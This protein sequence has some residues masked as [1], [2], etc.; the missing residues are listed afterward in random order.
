[1]KEHLSTRLHGI[2]CACLLMLTL[3]GC[4][5]TPNEPA[6]P[7]TA[8]IIEVTLR[9]ALPVYLSEWSDYE[10]VTFAQAS[11]IP[12]DVNSENPL[13]DIDPAILLRLEDVQL[14]VRRF[15]ECSLQPR[16]THPD[17][18]GHGICVW[19]GD[20]TFTSPTS[21]FVYEGYYGGNGAAAAHLY[22]V[23]YEARRWK[24]VRGHLLWIS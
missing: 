20:I 9:A 22:E 21:A 12:Y 19:I 6:T 2:L 10:F 24:I 15:S 4:D 7:G 1:M 23:R 11:W 16:V 5:E 3:P 13:G 14:P 17:F 8:P 18:S